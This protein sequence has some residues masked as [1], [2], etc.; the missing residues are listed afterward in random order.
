[1]RESRQVFDYLGNH[2]S[3]V[4]MQLG[5]E[6]GGNTAIFERFLAEWRAAD[7]RH[8]Y[9]IKANTRDNP[10]NIDYDVVRHVGGA[11]LRYQR[12]WPPRPEGSAFITQPPQTAIDWRQPVQAKAYPILQHESAQFCSY[13]DVLNQLPKFTGYLKPA[14]LDIA[15]DQLGERGMLDQIPAFV[16]AS[17]KWQVE[18]IR[19]EIEAAFRT[20]GLGGFHWL[21]LSDFTGQNCAL[22]GLTDPFWD[23]KPYVRP[24]DVRHFCAPTVL[25]AR[26]PQRVWTTADTFNAA[27]EVSHYG[28]EELQ[29]ND[30]QAVLRDA[31]GRAVKMWELP[32]SHFVQGSAQP[33]GR[34]EVPLGQLPAPAKYNLLLV[35]KKAGLQNDWD[36][37]V[38]PHDLE[39]EFPEGLVVGRGWDDTVRDALLAGKTVLLLPPIGSLKGD[40]PVCF[41]THYWTSIGEH[42]GQSSASGILLDPTHPLFASFPTEA[43]ANWHWWD[44]LT[45]CQPMILDQFEEARPWPRNYRPLIQPIDS[46]KDNRKLALVAE[47]KVGAGRLLICSIDIESDLHSRPATRQFRRSLLTYLQSPSFKP[48]I[49]VPVETVA[50]LFEKKSKTGKGNPNPNH[51]SSSLP[52]D[53]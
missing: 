19:E 46:W 36:L 25:L 3:F 1:M 9:S 52:T 44:L 33:A 14:Y 53:G 50:S 48:A 49:T 27:I 26:L 15:R 18:L 42:G 24:R 30:L 12:G 7:S 31:S 20:P 39:T 8:L 16:E 35:S 34:I 29:L 13:P 43:H 45:R 21:C 2:P 22:V 11:P 28:R 4:M 5:N 41:T 38:F 17:G 10:S 6:M 51:G 23:P 47:A 32:A 40:L 37:W